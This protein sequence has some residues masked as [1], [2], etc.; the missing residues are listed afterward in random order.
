MP[1]AAAFSVTGEAL[2]TDAI[3]GVAAQDAERYLLAL[4]AINLSVYDWNIETGAVD[5]PPLGH[6]IRRRWAEQPRNSS[7][8][9]RIIHPDDLPGYR[10]ALRAHLKGETSRL[11]H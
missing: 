2:P 10:A 4:A 1:T 9:T 7:D 3:T 6:A 11:E 8:W 5:H